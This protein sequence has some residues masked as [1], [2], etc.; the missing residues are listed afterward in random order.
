MKNLARVKQEDRSEIQATKGLNRGK[1]AGTGGFCLHCPLVLFYYM[2]V[3][4]LSA[5]T[6][7]ISIAQ[8][9]A[10]SLLLQDILGYGLN[11]T[12]PKELL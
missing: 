4:F 9:F 6:Y 7:L 5:L 12:K 3:V 8:V 10:P 11:S 1:Y 2:A